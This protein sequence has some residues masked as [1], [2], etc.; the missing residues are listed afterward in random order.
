MLRL[1]EGHEWTV[2]SVAFSPC[3]RFLVSGSVDTTVRVWAIENGNELCCF[4]HK[5][6][7][8]SV[9]LSSDSQFA[10]TGCEDN[11]VYLWRLP[12]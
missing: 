3:G 11:A 1:F 9:A 8:T 7:V 4:K 10:L 6:P 2:R 12:S 5:A